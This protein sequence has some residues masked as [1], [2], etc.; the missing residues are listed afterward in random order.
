MTFHRRDSTTDYYRIDDVT[1][2][3]EGMY[4]CFANNSKGYDYGETF[5]DVE[6]T[7]LLTC[8]CFSFGVDF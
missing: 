5:L 8:V 6:G 7:F 2:A 1:E 3:A 4:R